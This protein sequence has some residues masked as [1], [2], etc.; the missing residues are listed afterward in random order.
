M[1]TF[2]ETVTVSVADDGLVSLSVARDYD[3]GIKYR[4]AMFFQVADA[5]ALADAFDVMADT[6]GYEEV[7]LADGS[8]Y[9][10]MA[11]RSPMIDL[12][13]QRADELP[14]GGRLTMNVGLAS[15]ASI[16]AGL[17]AAVPAAAEPS[18]PA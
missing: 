15:A 5:P 9:L 8:L 12:D 14:H 11:E 10:A 7:T 13:L 1:D 4:S 2:S 3:D 6:L 18:P 16:S 17:R